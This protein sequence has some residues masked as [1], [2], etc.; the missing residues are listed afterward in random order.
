[1]LRRQAPPAASRSDW[2]AVAASSSESDLEQL[3]DPCCDRPTR[4]AVAKTSQKQGWRALRWH[5]DPH[6]I[7]AGRRLRHSRR[8]EPA[9]PPR[10]LLAS[11]ALRPAVLE[12]VFRAW[13]E[14]TDSAIYA[15]SG[16][17]CGPPGLVL[18][19][20][21]TLF[22]LHGI[23]LAEHAQSRKGGPSAV[24][25]SETAPTWCRSLRRSQRT[26]QSQTPGPDRGQG[27]CELGKSDPLT[28]AWRIYGQ[29]ES[30]MLQ[31]GLGKGKRQ[32][33]EESHAVRQRLSLSGR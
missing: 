20:D 17:G 16:A 18:R 12:S 8:P 24:R 19:F 22:F 28:P 14:A 13:A 30:H 26:W 29:H 7:A 10:C 1:M 4:E 32:Q 15:C 23:P 9:P 27:A 11:T 6:C 33:E 21:L 5:A 31:L 25:R 2:F 3:G